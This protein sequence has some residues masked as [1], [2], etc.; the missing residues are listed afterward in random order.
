MVIRSI[1]KQRDHNHCLLCHM[2]SD[3]ITYTVSAVF[4]VQNRTLVF[5]A[6]SSTSREPYTATT[7]RLRCVSCSIVEERAR[8]TSAK[9]SAAS[10]T[11]RMAGLLPF[12]LTPKDYELYEMSGKKSEEEEEDPRRRPCP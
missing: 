3:L 11:R 8:S 9:S 12:L 6:S 10:S 1:S 2:P 5:S 4:V 7:S